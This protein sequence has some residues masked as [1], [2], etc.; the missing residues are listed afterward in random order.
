MLDIKLIREDKNN[1]IE[2]L[3]RRG[4]DFTDVIDRIIK[5]DQDRRLILIELEGKKQQ[6]NS[7]SKEI[8]I[9]K[10]EGEEE[11]ADILKQNL[12][13]LSEE[14]K[15]ED[16]NITEIDQ[17]LK[18]LLLS[19]PNAL[20]LDVPLGKSAEDNT[21]IKVVGEA[22]LFDFKP[23]DHVDLGEALGYLDFD[24]AG[25][26]AGSRFPLL[27]GEGAKLERALINLMLDLQAVNGYTEVVPPFLA[28]QA[29]LTGTGQLPKFEE[30]LFKCRDDEYYLIPTAEVPLTNIHRNEFIKAE[31]LPLKYTAYTPCFRREAGSYGKDTRGLIRNH[32]FNKV[33]IVKLVKPQNAEKELESLL[34]DASMVLDALEL[35]YRVVKLCGGDTG[36]SAAKTY[37]L[38]VWMPSSE[39]Y[40]EISSC[41]LFTDF[42]ARRLNI[43]YKDEN[44]K[45]NFIYTLNGS[46]LAVGRTFAAVLENFQNAAGKLILPEI[47]QKYLKN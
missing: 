16:K 39:S 27:M 32:Q 10:Q 31:D 46:G 43:K 22:K 38:E 24:R 15:E 9:L 37:D 44:K 3:N 26:I 33:E 20:L 29:S 42:Q 23:K 12:K 1:I 5:K 40:R 21:I 47:L 45:T 8:G 17:S 28:N 30:D 41:S 4:R 6:L 11:K 14:I 36:F 19:I 18:F 2:R 34:R 35:P 25:K 7:S 13:Q